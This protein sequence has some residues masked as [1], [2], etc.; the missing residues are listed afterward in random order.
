MN[1]NQKHLYL[2][3]L[4]GFL[5]GVFFVVKIVFAPFH[6]KLSGLSKEIVLEEARYK[7]GVS[8]I[9]NQKVIE[10][11]YKKYAT[12]FSLQGFSDEEAVANFLKDVEKICRESGL[13][14]L[15]MKPQKE[16]KLDKFSKQYQIKIKVEANMD[17]MISFLY[18]LN[19][20]PLLFCVENLVLIPKSEAS[21]EV[22]V[23]MTV[24]G[25]SFQ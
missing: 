13:T 3:Y 19:E 8:L 2:I 24:V 7:K 14:I 12:Y 16:A 6:A 4:A 9:E 1:I 20:S 22:S 10:D 11:E 21:S 15:D 18:K 5:L 25:T 17:Q 23:S